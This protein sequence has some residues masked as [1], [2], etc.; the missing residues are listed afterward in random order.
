VKD[1]GNNV[2]HVHFGQSE[3]PSGPGRHKAPTERP[4][5][6]PDPIRELYTPQNVARLFGISLG[7]LRYW[8]RSDFLAPSAKIGKRSVYTFQDLI[9]IRT[10]HALLE[11]GVPLGS[12]RRSLSALRRTLPNVSRPL[13]EL[14]VVADGK[15]IVVKD[16]DT[17][18]DA[19][20]GQLL[21]DLDVQTIKDEVVT[22]LHKDQASE[23]QRRAAYRYYLEG[24]RFD[25]NQATYK[26]AE[27]AYR[28]AIELDPTFTNAL[29]NLGNLCYSQGEIRTALEFFEQALQHEPDHPEALYNIGFIL[30]EQGDVKGAAHCFLRAVESDPGFADAHFNAA[31]TLEDLHRAQEAQRHWRAYVDLDP[32]GP[33]ADIAARHLQRD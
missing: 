21:L 20:S 32:N 19:E 23:G 28:K 11:R 30:Y 33:W 3:A 10:A 15:Q 8:A 2:I 24:C 4:P 1:E 27:E 25:E 22:K 12:V 7:R 26:Q 16:G 6:P 17:A 18:F 31:M 9:S 5:P 14:R 29:T 13:G